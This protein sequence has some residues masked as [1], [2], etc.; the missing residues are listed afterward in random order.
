MQKFG[1]ITNLVILLFKLNMNVFHENYHTFDSEIIGIISI[2]YKSMGDFLHTW[3]LL[4]V[5][6]PSIRS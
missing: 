2:K 6:Q 1:T 5:R 3:P 4:S